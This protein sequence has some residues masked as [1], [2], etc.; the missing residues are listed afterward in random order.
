MIMAITLGRVVRN[1]E[2]IPFTKLQD[3]LI[4]WFCKLTLQIKY[5]ASLLTQGL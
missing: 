3:S 5:V 4:N 1:N 2:E